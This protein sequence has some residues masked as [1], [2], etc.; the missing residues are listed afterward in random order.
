[1]N[2]TLFKRQVPACIAFSLCL[3]LGSSA[4]AQVTADRAWVRA[5]VP[6]QG[7]TDAFMR[8]TADKDVQLKGVCSPAAGF[9]EVHEM[10]MDNGIMKMRTVGSLQLKAE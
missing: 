1:M 5:K 2:I 3:R 8:I 9:V 4:W 10:T 7:A 6:V